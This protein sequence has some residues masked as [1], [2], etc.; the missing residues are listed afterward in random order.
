MT[1]EDLC[2]KIILCLLDNPITEEE[3]SEELNVPLDEIK[4]AVLALVQ[5]GALYREEKK[6]GV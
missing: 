3:L 5:S 4:R 6:V 2:E 1:Q